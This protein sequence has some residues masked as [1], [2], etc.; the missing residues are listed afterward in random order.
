MASRCPARYEFAGNSINKN[1]AAQRPLMLSAFQ[2]ILMSFFQTWNYGSV[3]HE[4]NMKRFV[5]MM[6]SQALLFLHT[7]DE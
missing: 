3:I 6:S 4:L 7:L 5:Q 1:H 2:I